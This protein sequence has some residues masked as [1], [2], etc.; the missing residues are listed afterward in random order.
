MVLLF[1]LGSFLVT[2][3]SYVLGVAGIITNYSEIS[4]M[5]SEFFAGLF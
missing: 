2:A 3:F 5:L 1:A 4:G